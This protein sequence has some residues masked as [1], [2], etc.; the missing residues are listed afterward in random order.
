MAVRPGPRSDA[1]S[2][3]QP[4]RAIAP[5]VAITRRLLAALA[6]LL[7]VVAVVLI[8]RGGYRDVTGDRI[9]VLDAFY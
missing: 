1:E 6:I 2:V 7:A 8:D 5:V 3:R 9:G 4:A